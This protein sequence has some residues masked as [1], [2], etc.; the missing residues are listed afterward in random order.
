MEIAIIIGKA[1]IGIL[2]CCALFWL[3][4]LV[5]SIMFIS[6]NADELDKL[7]EHKRKDKNIKCKTK[8]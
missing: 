8:E 7:E 3:G 4:Y 5:S 1:L 6:K 2:A